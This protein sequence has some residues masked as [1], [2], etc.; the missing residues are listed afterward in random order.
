MTNKQRTSTL[1][2]TPGMT[3][4]YA[5]LTPRRIARVTIRDGFSGPL[6]VIVSFTDS[7][8]PVSFDPRRHVFTTTH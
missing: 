3:M 7:P 5:G 1:N 2:L 8:Q 6:A 4:L